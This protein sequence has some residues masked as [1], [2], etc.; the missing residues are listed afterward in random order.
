CS[1]GLVCDVRGR[2]VD[3]QSLGQVAAAAIPAP[4]DPVLA[5]SDSVIDIADASVVKHVTLHN[6]GGTPLSFQVHSNKTWIDVQPAS[7]T[8]LAPGASVT[9]TLTII[10]QAVGSDDAAQLTVISNGG[11]KQIPIHIPPRLTGLFHGAVRISSPFVLGT[12][13]L[14][15]YLS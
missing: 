15:I 2:C 11:A 4:G 5:L 14:G 9:L 3:K 8:A 6:D 7:G 12:R 1:A 13:S 10:Q